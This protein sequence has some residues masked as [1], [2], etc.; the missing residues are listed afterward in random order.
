MQADPSMVGEVF[1][2]G[3]TPQSLSS[4]NVEIIPSVLGRQ[5]VEMYSPSLRAAEGLKQEKGTYEQLRKMMLN[6]G[7]KA[8][9][10]NWS[11]ANA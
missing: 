6:E 4:A 9:E 11:G 10:L 5:D 2:R 7:A 3:G 1:Q 8:D